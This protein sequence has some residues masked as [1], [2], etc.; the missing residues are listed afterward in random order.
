MIKRGIKTFRFPRMERRGS[1]GVDGSGALPPRDANGV[2]R[3][4]L[5]VNLCHA[6]DCATVFGDASRAYRGLHDASNCL[7]AEITGD[8]IEDAS[9]R[10]FETR[11]PAGCASFGAR[12]MGASA[13][14]IEMCLP[15]AR[16][17][18]WTALL[19]RHAKDLE[20]LKRPAAALAACEHPRYWRWRVSQHCAIISNRL[21][22]QL[23]KLSK[24]P[25]RWKVPKF[26]C[27][28][29]VKS[30]SMGAAAHELG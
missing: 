9:A 15:L 23:Q 8:V 10:I 6:L 29:R 21:R 1:Q 11:G 30:P 22:T 2:G 4:E 14:Y 18:A 27:A 25:R 16:A 26:D 28:W 3:L 5:A 7:T 20:H 24:P 19:V 13:H 12:K 17:C